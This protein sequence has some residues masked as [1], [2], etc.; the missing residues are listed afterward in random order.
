MQF[1]KEFFV[2]MEPKERKLGY[3]ELTTLAN[4]LTVGLFMSLRNHRNLKLPQGI[5]LELQWIKKKPCS[6][7]H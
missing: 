6:H 1:R 3:E 2:R 4:P 5:R 7:M